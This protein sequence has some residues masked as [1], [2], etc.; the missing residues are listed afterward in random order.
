MILSFYKKYKIEVMIFFLALL[1]RTILFSINL[2]HNNYNLVDT[3]HGDDGYYE[4]SQGILAGNGFTGDVLPPHRPNPLRP[5]VWPFLIAFLAK[6]FG[7]YWAVATFELIIGSLIPVLGYMITKNIFSIPKVSIGTGILMA[8]EPYSILLS[9]LLYSETIF[10]FLFLLFF[11]FL[12]RYFK[13]F[14]MRD[15]VWMSLFLGLATMSKLTIQYIPIVLIIFMLIIHH[16]NFGSV[17]WKNIS[18]MLGIFLLLIIP[19]LGRNYVE[20]GKL[21]LSAQPP[22]N[23]YVY[24]VPTVLSID[25]GTSFAVEHQNFVR[26]NNFDENNI[27][28]SN[29]DYYAEKAL[30]ILKDHKVALIKSSLTTI[31]TFFTHDGL[32]AVFQNA[33]IIIDNSTNRPALSMLFDDPLGLLKFIKAQ[34]MGLGVLILIARLVWI[35]ITVL[36]IIGII[37][38]IRTDR[39][40]PAVWMAIILV[41]YFM[42]TT[43]I[44]GLGVNAR[45]KVPVEVFLFSFALYGLFSLKRHNILYENKK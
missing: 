14:T 21:G 19:W 44:N 37:R 34:M 6:F 12:I 3:I 20:F 7:S 11:Y 41:L 42:V 10:T 8:F 1:A 28:L 43:A 23:L 17:R 39:T 32:L 13:S 27:N 35:L 4:I 5:P 26:R 25:N 36:F 40:N 2:D 15:L 9:S 45:F 38:F 16:K 33:G 24:L 30:D 18:I 29:G 22:F 31:V